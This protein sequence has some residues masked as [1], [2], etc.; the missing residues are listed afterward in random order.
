MELISTYICKQ[1]DIGVHN[2]M[3]GG[4]ILSII[5]DAA[6]SYASQICDTQRVVTLK[7]DEL[8]FK[9]PVKSGNILK[10]YGSVKEFGTTSV[11]LY[12]EVRKHNV[13]TGV[14]KVVTHTN[15]KFVRIDDEGEPLAISD[16]VKTRYA[17]RVK[18]FGRALLTP[19]EMT[20]SKAKKPV[21]DSKDWDSTLADGLENL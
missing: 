1:G 16:R 20:R 4:I 2:N 6:A 5:D 14:Q 17:D 11:T 18:K 10:I 7:I 19:E 8:V 15:M 21:D 3:F 13:Y 9:L 12:I